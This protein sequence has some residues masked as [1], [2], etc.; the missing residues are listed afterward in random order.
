MSALEYVPEGTS[1]KCSNAV[2]CVPAEIK[3]TNN[4]NVKLYGEKMASMADITPEVNIPCF[5]Q[6]K[7]GLKTCVPAPS[8]W[9]NVSSLTTVSGSN[10]L[11]SDSFLMCGQGGK[12][13][14][15]LN[16]TFTKEKDSIL[17]G[18]DSSS[19]GTSS[20][21]SGSGAGG[22]SRGSG[23]G[24]STSKSEEDLSNLP[25]T[26]I[27]KTDEKGFR[28][29]V[30]DELR[31]DIASNQDYIREN[32]NKTFSDI[33]FQC[34]AEN[35]THAIPGI[36]FMRGCFPPPKIIDGLIA[37]PRD[38]I[39]SRGQDIVASGTTDIYD[40]GV[41]VKD[42]GVLGIQKAGE[43]WDA[44]PETFETLSNA[45]F[46]DYKQMGSDMF[47]NLKNLPG[48]VGSS[49]GQ[50]AGGWLKSKA[51][52][53]KNA[54]G[55]TKDFAADPSALNGSIL[56]TN[57]SKI[58]PEGLK[59]PIKTINNI[60]KP[61]K[62]KAASVE[63]EAARKKKKEAEE[64][65]KKKEAEEARKAEEAKK[66]R[67]TAICDKKKQQ[68]Q[69]CGD[70]VDIVTGIVV[71]D[72]VDFEIPGIIPLKWERN[73]YSDSEYLGPL[74]HGVHHS[75]DIRI[76]QL[77]HNLKVILPDGRPAFFPIIN[78]Q[79]NSF[80]NLKEKLTLTLA[81]NSDYQLFD[82]ETQLTYTFENRTSEIKLSKISN[83]DGATIH[84]QYINTRLHRIVDT[85]GRVIKFHANENNLISKITL[86]HKGKEKTL[87]K[88]AYNDAKDMVVITDALG[89]TTRATYKNHLMFSKTDRNGQT[90]YW[91]Y[92][93]FKTG[94]KCVHT[95]GDGGVLDYIIEYGREYNTITNSLGN[96]SLYYY[97]GNL[98]TKIVDPL[99]G[100]ITKEYDENQN[101][102]KFINE[103]GNQTNYSYDDKGNIIEVKYNDGASSGYAYDDKGRLQLKTFPEGGSLIKSYKKNR[104]DCIISPTGMMTTFDYDEH[105]LITKVFDNLDNETR[106]FYD[107]DKNLIKIKL[108]NGAISSWE[109][110]EWGQCI[111]AIN[112]E[113]HKQQF[114]YDILG[115]VTQVQL[116]DSNNIQLKY[117]GYEQV[118]EAVDNHR[119]LKFEYTPVGSLKTREENGKKVYFR[120]DNEDQLLGV[121][122]R[123]GESYNFIRD[124]KGNIIEEQGYD[125]ITRYFQRDKAGKVSKVERPGEKYS[126][127]EYDK[128]GRI[129]RVE[130]HDGTWATYSYNKDGLL[131]EAINPNSHV[132]LNRDEAGRIL[133]ENQ[134]GYII[135][136]KYGEIG[137][138]TGIK[139]SLG[140]NISF[141]HSAIGE[142]TKT[143][144]TNGQS[145]PWEAN[146]KYNSLGMETERILSGGI[147]STWKYDS[148]GRP[149]QQ[150]VNNQRGE[151]R[152]RTYS[153]D[154]NNKLKRIIDNFNNGMVNFTYDDFNN[155]AT[156]QY[157][158]GSY[159][160]KLPD[161]VGNLYRTKD[162][163]DK[164]YGKSG[165]L[166]RSGATTY[167]Y[168]EEGNLIEKNT[169]KG[170]WKY[171]W[172]AGG[173]LQSVIKPDKTKIEFEYDAL[174]RRTTK[175]VKT[176]SIKGNS[177][178][179]EEGQ[180]GVITRWIWDGNVPLHEWK[181][182]L[183]N[184]PKTIVDT[185][186][187]ISKNV[188]EPVQDIITW[189]FDQGTFRPA[190]KI[191]AD[192][193][194]SI[195]TD[196]LGTPVEMYNSK[197]EK[198]WAVE[199]DI[200]G[201]I[202]K[203]VTG[204][205]NDCPYRYQGQYE[206]VETG[207]YYNRFRYYSPDSGTYIS[208]DPIR[209]SGNNPNIYAYTHDSNTWIDIFGL[210]EGGSNKLGDWGENY[211]KE[212]L[213][214]SGEY[215]RVFP[216]Q[217]S[218]NHGIDLVGETHDGKF[219]FFEV[220]TTG[221]GPDINGNRKVWKLPDRQSD[222]NFFINDILGKDN[223][224]DFGLSRAEADHILSNIGKK[225]LV[226]VFVDNGKVN[227]V[228]TS[229][230]D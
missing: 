127:Y 12:I 136:S 54:W 192:D 156:A 24:N 96:Q 66:Q 215:K 164:E 225:R 60:I 184:R 135:T 86:H 104:L 222:S 161:E 155:L 218:Q 42:I 137:L 187:K 11:L 134:D 185:S 196:Y 90:Y 19:D 204:S 101:L 89:Q 145:K 106:L 52:D 141:E 228:L 88:Y 159:D 108:P 224:Q 14:I 17:S 198:T 220:K 120:Y 2:S 116:P 197:G 59:R 193:T 117:N 126:I 74:G 221:V 81:K 132:K 6:C 50:A 94:A 138:R 105:G 162:K 223:I 43:A 170:T 200:Y 169:P 179:L 68:G 214:K 83:T 207:L 3:V 173:M 53:V 199:Y 46:E 154:V 99:G 175:I 149:L 45:S 35:P 172:E 85:I 71:Y 61:K 219:D 191:T 206:D 153:W 80:Y 58:I 124:A 40:L 41:T 142:G 123:Q 8:K 30:N 209:L 167:N 186:G 70:P 39:I 109:Y 82:H 67:E 229:T 176:S 180:G 226:D 107:E 65:R 31:Q 79:I 119:T 160:Y 7:N 118:I 130:H 128:G 100:E 36:D 49:I 163:N 18:N 146:Y 56:S 13:E 15:D 77:K 69:S 178:L 20:N 47:D 92:D 157:E 115:R 22:S 144:A 212:Q 48:K 150:K 148:A 133:S 168:D 147:K 227:K 213:E 78:T 194:Y 1:L 62:G 181:Y 98:A 34:L 230:W 190:A 4:K 216:I 121:I 97:N 112:P 23:S 183:K 122:N 27:D 165:K 114:H 95:W 110:D 75:Y 217:N 210:K 113:K 5:G 203:L 111:A 208:Q 205:L 91:E 211:T 26:I 189:V 202:R 171:K 166:L 201:K 63:E 84:F 44:S 139:S 10:Y 9:E 73:W 25:Q 32:N 93:G 125:D 37:I 152:S 177:S 129:S 38:F 55:A 151:Q 29:L 33:G 21:G 103:E 64:A 188:K 182:D 72:Y 143:T 140:A 16:V 87:V 174:G 158:D 76:K 131:V 28:Y 195:I 57:V 102:I 51:D